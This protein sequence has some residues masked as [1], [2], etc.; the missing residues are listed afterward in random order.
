MYKQKGLMVKK[1]AFGLSTAPAPVKSPA[2]V[3]VKATVQDPKNVDVPFVKGAYADQS[4][5][6][7]ARRRY[8]SDR[9]DSLNYGSRVGQFQALRDSK[10]WQERGGGQLADSLLNS[11][12]GVFWDKAATEGEQRAKLGEQQY[13]DW[14]ALRG[15][16]GSQQV[17]ANQFMPKKEVTDVRAGAKDPNALK[18]GIRSTLSV[19]QASRRK[20]VGDW[21]YT[22]NKTYD[23]NKAGE[24]YNTTFTVAPKAPKAP[25]VRKQGGLIYG[26]K[27]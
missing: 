13:N 5:K 1:A 23:A 19:P 2:P 20:T 24:E 14:V 11:P 7:D 18:W 27:F 26:K 3:P 22:A 21:T 15:G 10:R 8:I 16:L 4:F 17:N 12:E 6:D 25:V 9:L